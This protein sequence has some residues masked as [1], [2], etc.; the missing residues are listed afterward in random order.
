MIMTMS[1]DDHFTTLALAS[2]HFP[3]CGSRALSY[4]CSGC[5]H[6]KESD[7]ERTD[8][9]AVVKLKEWLA[10]STYIRIYNIYTAYI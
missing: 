3:P 8:G 5:G 7:E 1:N 9:R 6:I 2:S 10:Y 4:E